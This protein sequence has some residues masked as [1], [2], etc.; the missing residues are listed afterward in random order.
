[1]VTIKTIQELYPAATIKQV[2]SKQMFIITVSSRSKLL[3]YKT[4]VGLL[5]DDVWMLTPN[6][7]SRTTSKQLT[8]FARSKLVK[9]CNEE[10]WEALNK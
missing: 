6:K 2:D 1:M 4:I 10:E 9:W 8:Q 7:H 5:V 3:S